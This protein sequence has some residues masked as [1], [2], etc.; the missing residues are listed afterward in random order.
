MQK[1]G[2]ITSTADANGE[3]TNGN[4]AAGTLPTILDAAWFNTVQR[5]LA[6]VVTAGGL[7]LDSSND[8]Q[9]LAALKLLI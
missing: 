4:V 6:D 2:S 3:W 7:S 1:I 9:V 8:A 5:E